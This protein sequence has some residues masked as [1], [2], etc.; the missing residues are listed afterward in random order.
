MA[1]KEIATFVNFLS[2]IPLKEK[3]GLTDTDKR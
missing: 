2:K 3:E 1:E